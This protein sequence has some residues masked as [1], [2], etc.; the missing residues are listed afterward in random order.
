[1]CECKNTRLQQDGAPT[2]LKKC[3]TMNNKIKSK[4][5]KRRNGTTATTNKRN[6]HQEDLKGTCSSTVRQKRKRYFPPLTNWP[7]VENN[8]CRFSC[9]ALSLA[10]VVSFFCN[11]PFCLSFFRAFFRSFCVSLQL[12]KPSNQ[13][14]HHKL[15][16]TQA[17]NYTSCKLHKLQ[18]T[19]VANYI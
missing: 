10:F 6:N 19:Q 11:R 16:T 8:V 17:T 9:K 15:Q 13:T 1:M 4:A 14:N 12:N 18:T 7:V 3:T 5:L 2:E